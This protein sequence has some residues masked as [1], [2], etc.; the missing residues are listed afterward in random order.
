MASPLSRGFWRERSRE[1]D[2]GMRE[3]V[4]SFLEGDLDCQGC[5]FLLECARRVEVSQLCPRFPHRLIT[6][7]KNNYVAYSRN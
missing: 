2:R 1:I 7:G 5:Q 4:M 3:V 6:K